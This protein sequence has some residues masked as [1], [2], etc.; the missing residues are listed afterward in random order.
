MNEK[1]TMNYYEAREYIKAVAPSGSV[2]GL[3]DIKN[4]L[5]KLNNPQDDLKFIH[6]AGTNGKG[7]VTAYI[8]TILQVARYK[9]GRYISPTIYDYREC[10]QINGEYIR[11]EAFAKHMG[12]IAIAVERMVDEGLAKP[13]VFEIETALSFLHFKEEQCDL[14]VLEAGMGG[15]DDATNVVSNTI[16][17]ILTSISMDHMEFLGDSLIKIA[18]NKAGIIKPGAVVVCDK[19]ELEVEEAIWAFCTEQGNS[20]VI[21]KPQVAVIRE[22]TLE[23]QVF[24]YQG[25]EISI[26]LAGT[27]QIEN[28]V[29]ALEGV[30]ALTQLGYNISKEDIKRGFAKTTWEGR[31]TVLTREPYFVVDGAHNLAAANKLAQS[32]KVYFPERKFI[33]IMGILKDKPYQEIAELM[34]PLADW[35]FTIETPDNHRALPADEL[36]KIVKKYNNHVVVCQT[37]ETAVTQSFKVANDTDVIVAFGS[38]SFIGEI[39]ECVDRRE[40]D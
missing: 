29:V 38:L 34:A 27:H 17:A 40:N 26:H 37:I 33:F 23:H 18:L 5:A 6:I 22:A 14:V 39:T 19:Q 15:R 9:V 12:R 28:A 10:I 32:L 11:R 4:L 3:S 21:A 16:L 25:D 1:V 35:I 7:S 8:S 13:T 31:F 30:N 36:A 24:R 2:L 20:L